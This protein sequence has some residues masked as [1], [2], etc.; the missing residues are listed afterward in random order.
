ATRPEITCHT[1]DT[2]GQAYNQYGGNSLY[3]G[4]PGTNPSRAYKVSYNRPFTTRGTSPEYWVFNAEYPMVRW[5]EA[6]GYHVSYSTGVD[7]DRSGAQLLQH[8]VF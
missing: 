3:V 4:G 8:R 5:L 6:N 1:S 7:S 2:T